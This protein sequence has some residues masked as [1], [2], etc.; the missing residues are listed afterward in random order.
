ML[1]FFR[2][3]TANT[4]DDVLSGL[5]VALALVPEAVAFAFVA[6]VSPLIGLY[7]AVFIGLITAVLGGRPGMISGATGAMAVVVVGL[8]TIH[9]IEY[10]F[11][12]VIL[13]GLIQIAIGFARLGKLIRMVPHSVM[14]GF[15]NG[16]AIVIGM[17]QLGSF[18]ILDLDAGEMVYLSGIRLWLML[19]LVGLTML[20]IVGLPRF[21]KAI[22][23]SLAAILV[24]TMISVGI[25]R[26]GQIAGDG[27]SS[28]AIATVGDMLATHATAATASEQLANGQEIVPV[29][30]SIGGG[31]PKLFFMEYLV[32]EFSFET[33][34]IIFPFALT[35]A[36]VGLIESL[37]T[38][39]LIDEITETRGRGNRECVGQGVANLV[40]GL[41]GGMGGCAMIGQSLINVNSGGRGRLSGITAA[42]CLMLFILFVAPWIEMIPMAALVGVM[43][44]VVIGTFEWA[45]IKMISRIPPSDYFVMVLVAGY[46]VVMHDLATAVILGVVVSACVFAWKHATHLG[47]DTKINEEGSKVYQLHGPLFFAS[48]SSF[49]ELFDVQNDPED[50]VIDFYY[51]RVYDQSGMEAIRTL[52]EKYQAANKRLHLTHLSEEC[53]TL[54]DRAGELVEVNLSE[55]PQYHVAT[56]RLA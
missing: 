50:V 51:T 25:N 19:G 2:R 44:M 20:I 16:L 3:Q 27:I 22:P 48:A 34:K 40:C 14:L 26:S 31:L 52:T 53:R 37:M 36:G 56:D 18:K 32:P 55:D 21:T 30:A 11:P 15:V 54:L 45:S 7:S 17:A 39:T 5:T 24:V 38:L 46:T 42:C 41:F 35:L 43:F 28:N 12:A 4:K 8:V 49:K 9:G 13:C 10:M 6:G 1:N 29:E 23:A 47:A 33:L